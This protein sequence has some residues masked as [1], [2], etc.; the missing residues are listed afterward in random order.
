MPS[1]FALAKEQ[2]N[3]HIKKW[4]S[5]LLKSFVCPR[6]EREKSKKK[7]KKTKKQNPLNYTLLVIQQHPPSSSNIFLYAMQ[8]AKTQESTSRSKGISFSILLGCSH[9]LPHIFNHFFLF[10]VNKELVFRLDLLFSFHWF[11]LYMRSL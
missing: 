4:R 10:L 2:T 9:Y 7:K 8:Y 3:R 6:Q 1:P 11:Q 5:F